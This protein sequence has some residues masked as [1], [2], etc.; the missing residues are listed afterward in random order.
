VLF[1]AYAY[2][3][4]IFKGVSLGAVLAVLLVLWPVYYFW[5]WFKGDVYHNMA[6]FFSKQGKWEEAI[7]YYKRVNKFNKYFIMPYYFVGNV[8]ND[9][10]NMER[11]Y[12]SE[13][14]DENSKPRTDF[15]RAMDS[16][17]EVRAI[18]PNY[19]Q[20]HHQVGTLY[21]K[22]FDY[23]NAQG[24]PQEAQAYLDKALARL[25]IYENLD[26]VYPYNYYRKAQIYINRKQFDKAE[27]E[28]LHHLN[29]WK[30]YVKGHLHDSAE[31][32]TNLANVRYAMGKY[33]EA[34]ADY[35]EALKLDPNYETAKRNLEVLRERFGVTPPSASEPGGPAKSGK[36]AVGLK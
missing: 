28:Y 34:A 16:Y 8:F 14:G 30:C 7:T 19:V 10:L 36:Q 29:A 31:A 26:P 1:F 11:Q 12:R 25:N 15:E 3:K 20:M 27:T 24:K 9:R 4:I 35:R 6:I 21:M 2:A 33:K 13:W 32:Y 17:E 5:G 22:M 18:A 23:S